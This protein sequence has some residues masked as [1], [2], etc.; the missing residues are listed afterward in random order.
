M[1]A[2]QYGF[3]L[4]A[5]YDMTIIDRRIAERGPS[6]DGFPG[7][8]FKAYLSAR[9][10]GGS[11]PSTENLY[12]PF[13]LWDE[14]GGVDAFLSGPGF[15]GVTRDFGW[16]QVRTWLVWQAVLGPDLRAARFASRET[17][18]IAPYADLASLRDTAAA[19]ARSAVGEGALAAVAAFD[20]SAWT[21][22]RFQLWRTPPAA[23]GE[24]AQLY[25]VGHVSLP[26]S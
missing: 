16:P 19:E 24:G 26:K 7:L 15:A 18:P 8:R 5:D 10:R 3:V 1:I 20:P 13:Y 12:A 25:A 11:T 9:R 23:P 6:L 17:T 4:P 2:M 14:P 21:M 22:V